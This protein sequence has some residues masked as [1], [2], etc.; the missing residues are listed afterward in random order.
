VAAVSTASVALAATALDPTRLPLGDGKYLTHPKKGYVDSC[1]TQ[2]NG[3]GAFRNGPWIDEAA[4]TWDSR[5]KVAVQGAVRWTSHFS[6]KVAG[7]KRVLAGN[8]LPSHATGVFPVAASDP[9]YQY[10]RNPNSIRA[11]TLRA[12]LPT[13]PKLVANPSCVGG[14]VGV[15]KDGVPLFSAFDA[16]GRDAGAHEIQDACGGHPQMSGQYHYHGLPPCLASAGSKRP[17]LLGWALDGFGIYVE[18]GPNGAMLG[19]S[20][21]DACHGRTS[22]VPWNGKTVRIYHYVAT[23]DFPYTVGC[24]RGTP[25][26]SATG[27]QIGRGG[28]P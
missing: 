1:Q 9:A 12:S 22:S 3:G 11:Y 8:G 28:P 14:T 19:T 26:T 27:L 13:S 15:I 24:F 16:G 20:D 10:D 5:R 21:L 25:I 23:L 17:Q 7:A 4:K 6:A 18:Y 2:F